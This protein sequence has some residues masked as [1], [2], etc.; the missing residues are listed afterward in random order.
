MPLKGMLYTLI[1]LEDNSDW[2]VSMR[3]IKFIINVIMSFLLMVFI[4]ICIGQNFIN[5]KLLNK[6]YFKAKL[7]I[8]VFI[9][10]FPKR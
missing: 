9:V 10:S 8:Q 3:V 2:R 6:D 5:N 7:M 1:V 4:A